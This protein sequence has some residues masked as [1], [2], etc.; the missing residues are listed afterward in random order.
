[1]PQEK[2]E[3][4]EGSIKNALL[5]LRYCAMGILLN[6]ERFVK[7]RLLNWLEQPIKAYGSQ[8]IDSNLYRLLNQRLSQTLT[9]K[10]MGYLNPML[11]LVQ[12]A[13]LG[14]EETIG[15]SAIGW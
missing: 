12:S 7:D 5:V 13:L 11:N 14:Q 2:V 1:M 8:A 9:P 4:L 6:D 15:S 3:R 10:Q